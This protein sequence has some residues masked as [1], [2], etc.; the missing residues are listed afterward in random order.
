V[1]K[2]SIYSTAET[3]FSAIA[4]YYLYR[5]ITSAFSYEVREQIKQRANYKS[6]LS[7]RDDEPLECAHYNH[8]KHNP[9]YNDP[10]NG[11]LLLLSEHLQ[12]HIDREG[13]NGLSSK[14][15]EWAI[16]TIESR[17]R[18]FYNSRAQLKRIKKERET[19][20]LSL[21]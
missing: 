13:V 8:D 5:I 14:E 4:L 16:R 12:D 6:E 15:N 19:T 10:D 1:R 11:R 17:L 9:G 2:E 3:T 20:Q 21:L 18:D 7:G